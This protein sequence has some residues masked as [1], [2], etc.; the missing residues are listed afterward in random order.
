MNRKAFVTILLILSLFKVTDILAASTLTGPYCFGTNCGGGDT[1]P[2]APKLS[3]FDPSSGSSI[4][5]GG[6]GGDSG[7][8]EQPS[9]SPGACTG[10]TPKTPVG[11]TGTNNGCSVSVVK[12]CTGNNGCSSCTKRKRF[13]L[14][15]TNLQETQPETV[16]MVM[17]SQEYILSPNRSNP[18]KIKYPSSVGDVGVRVPSKS[19]PLTASSL[20]YSFRVNN[21]GLNDEW[22]EWGD[23]TTPRTEDFCI[24]GTSNTQSFQPS[25]LDLY[26]VLR[27]NSEGQVG[28]MYYTV[29]RCDLE[30]IYSLP[31]EGY[32]VVNNNPRSNID[33]CDWDSSLLA[34]DP[35]CTDGNGNREEVCSML[36]DEECTKKEILP[37]LGSTDSISMR[38]CKSEEYSGNE[39]NNA[40]KVRIGSTDPDGN[41]EIRGAVVW[42]GKSESIPDKYKLPKIVASYDHTD[43]NEVG[44]MILDEKIYGINTN[45]SWAILDDNRLKNSQGENILNVSGLEVERGD[46]TVTFTIDIEFLRNSSQEISGIYNF[47]QV[48]LDEY[49]VLEDGTVDQSYLTRYFNWGIDLKDPS[50]EK[51]DP[52]V[53]GPRDFEM[54]IDIDGTESLV[55]DVII[56][57]YKAGGLIN[58]TIQLLSPSSLLPQQVIDVST[59]IPEIDKIGILSEENNWHFR[60]IYTQQVQ[61]RLSANIGDSEGGAI[62][63]YL[64]AFDQACNS[65]SKEQ[66]IDLTPWISTKGGVVYSRG[67]TGSESKDVSNVISLDSAIRNIKK[68]EL[69]S[70]T[71]LLSSKMEYIAPIKY[72]DTIGGVRALK[73]N[74]TNNKKNYWYEYFKRKLQIQKESL[75]SFLLSSNTST[76]SSVCTSDNC[77]MESEES[78]SVPNNLVCDRNTLIISDKDIFLNPDILDNSQSTKGCIF[79]A[80]NNIYIGGGDRKSGTSVGYDYIES[81]MIAG[82]QII[83]EPD[84]ITESVRDALEIKGGAIALG[85]NAD[86]SSAIV[87]SRNLRLNNYSF[88][89]LVVT[90]DIKY[91]RLSEIFFGVESPM[92]KQEIGFKIF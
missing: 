80:K 41:T 71:E 8:D 61:E 51:S 3:D 9:C 38:G 6:G 89:T 75:A 23:C 60:N 25:S 42:F 4:S 55:T 13:W 79:L 20:G 81:F 67:D 52:V 47:K 24:E 62:I 22:I 50:V 72:A 1:T 54:D 45:G 32:Y 18:T 2:V 19:T 11:Y 73:I 12:T 85:D 82:N 33:V 5:S 68:E 40:L 53:L 78:I 16:S 83:I 14:I 26:T 70:A 36:P 63:M 86:N 84:N 91:A 10:C 90:W 48:V 92:Y 57:S 58:G 21:Y 37:S 46:K 64:T 15:E 77:F 27:S 30:R 88:P 44:I 76:I 39:I 43:T 17:D 65:T 28:G 74:D 59:S 29:N 69:T 34:S 35:N 31:T 66:K 87:I 7:G 56:N 49:M